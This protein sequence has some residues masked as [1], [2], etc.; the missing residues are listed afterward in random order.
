MPTADEVLAV[1]YSQVG[2]EESGDG[3]EYK[4]CPAMGW[5]PWSAWCGIFMEWCVVQAGGSRG[6]NGTV[7]LLHYTPTAAEAY[8]QRGDW[9]ATPTRGAHCFFDWGG[10]GLGSS[11]GLIDH[12]GIVADA[13]TWGEGWITTVEGNI[14]QGGNP[15][16]GEFQR[17]VSVLSGFGMPRYSTT[18]PTPPVPVPTQQEDPM[19]VLRNPKGWHVVAGNQ[20]IR[21]GGGKDF[22]MVR[23]DAERNLVRIDVSDAELARWQAAFAK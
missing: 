3:G 23:S 6:D 20:L 9:S 15:S 5:D 2:Y 7:P 13:S 8:Q 21:V 14:T 4:F 1:A 22:K 19:I 11:T 17:S 12:I 10:G 16:V 18:Q